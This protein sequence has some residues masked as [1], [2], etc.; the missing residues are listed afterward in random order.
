M[1]GRHAK[2]FVSPLRDKGLLL[3]INQL[4]VEKNKA[5]KNCLQ[6]L[7]TDQGLRDSWFSVVSRY[8]CKN[9]LCQLN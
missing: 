9:V 6:Q 7:S 8:G 3:S 1:R 2:S 5:V 4:V